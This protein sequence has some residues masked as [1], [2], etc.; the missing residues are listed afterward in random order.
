MRP[1]ILSALALCAAGCTSVAPV[2]QGAV[3]RSGQLTA[4]Q[5]ED[6]IKR[7]D[8]RTV[9]NLRGYQPSSKWYKAQTEVVDRL[10]VEQ[11]DMEIGNGAPNDKQ[12]AELMDVFQRAPKPILVHSYFS[13]GATGLAS[14]MYRMGMEGERYNAAKAELAPWQKK[15]LPLAPQKEHDTFLAAWKP[16]AAAAG[17]VDGGAYQVAK[18]GRGTESRLADL[19]RELSGPRGNSRVDESAPAVML[20]PPRALSGMATLDDGGRR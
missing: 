5:L 15:W 12:V 20:G 2:R 7:N 8:I 10:G 14:G 9:V 13:K 6:T 11:V 17:M 4:A 19:D 3:Y 16:P 18:N 1:W